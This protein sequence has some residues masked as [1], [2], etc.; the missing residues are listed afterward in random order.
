MKKIILLIGLLCL[1]LYAQ[2]IHVGTGN[3]YKP[4]AYVGEN[5]KAIGFDIDVLNLL[6]HYDK[7]LEFEFFPLPWNALFVGLDSAK[8]DML[9]HQITK[10]K[11]REEKYIFSDIPYFQAT[12]NF[13]V[14]QD[15][16]ISSWEDL[17]H[18]KIGVVVGSNQALQVEQWESKHKDY[19]IKLVYFKNY[20]TQLLALANQQ[21]DALLD[22]PIV[23]LDYAKAQGVK[24]Q[25]TNLILQKTAIFFVFPKKSVNL[26]NRISNA[27]LK[28]RQDG[29]LK[30]L[31]L[32]Y[33]NQDF[34]E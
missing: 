20:G 27:L 18:K 24:I 8:F 15:S 32:Q 13:I 19:N 7:S 28:A 17:K 14:L 25:V 34:T 33:F 12:L 21:I 6:S 4:F 29:K 3:S 5:G 2:K 26:K 1:S 30:E 16:K 22:T 31:S 9:A 11:L 10:T 23:A